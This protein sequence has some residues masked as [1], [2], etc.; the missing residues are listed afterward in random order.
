[1]SYHTFWCL[2]CQ[3]QIGQIPETPV[4]VRN[5]G[6][7]C[8]FANSSF[9]FA[10]NLV[11]WQTHFRLCK[12]KKLLNPGALFQFW[13]SNGVCAYFL[14]DLFGVCSQE[15]RQE[16]VPLCRNSTFSQCC[17]TYKGQSSVFIFTFPPCLNSCSN[18]R[19][20]CFLLPEGLCSFL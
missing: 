19:G 2:H 9:N 4:E 11:D 17:A 3:K 7:E 18:S 12:T 15:G 6:N 10:S 20:W 16:H 14:Q 5:S 13:P 1:M 8:R